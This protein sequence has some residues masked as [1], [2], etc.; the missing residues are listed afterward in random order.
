MHMKVRSLIAV[1]FAVGSAGAT[2]DTAAAFLCTFALYR[3]GTRALNI[4][5]ATGVASTIRTPNPT[6]VYN[7]DADRPI[8][9]DTYMFNQSGGG[10]FVQAGWYLGRASNLPTTT[11]PRVFWGENT[12]TGETLHAGAVLSWDTVYSFMI[13]NPLDGSNRFNVWFQGDIIG[14]SEYGHSLNAPAFNGEVDYKCTRMHGLAAHGQAPLRTLQYRYGS[15]SYFSG[16]TFHAV[17][18][19]SSDAGD[20]ATNFVYGGG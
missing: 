11:Q 20:I 10:A 16:T 17:D 18:F 12:P 3:A 7:Y 4:S 9:A 8:A 19:F 5:V 1:L 2:A 15:W 14:Q 13:T 6:D